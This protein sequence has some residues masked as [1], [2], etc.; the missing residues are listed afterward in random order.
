MNGL[1]RRNIAKAWIVLAMMAAGLSSSQPLAA[2]NESYPPLPSAEPIGGGLPELGHLG[3][4]H[5]YT[6]TSGRTMS[7]AGRG[8]G[9]LGIV[10]VEDPTAPR[11][12]GEI[13]FTAERPPE[14]MVDPD[15]GA[16]GGDP[17]LSHGASLPVRWPA[18]PEA[19]PPTVYAEPAFVREIVLDSVEMPRVAYVAATGPG[20]GAVYVVDVSD[21][22]HLRQAAFVQLRPPPSVSK[23][24]GAVPTQEP[25]WVPVYVEPTGLTKSGNRLFAATNLGLFA[26]DVTDPASPRLVSPEPAWSGYAAAVSSDTDGSVIVV[27]QSDAGNGLWVLD[28]MAGETVTDR[29][30]VELSDDPTYVT[31]RAVAA[32]DGWYAVADAEKGVVVVHP[33]NS[34]VAERVVRYPVPEQSLDVAWGD[35]GLLYVAQS[36]DIGGPGDA[37]PEM[38]YRLRGVRVIDPSKPADAPEDQWTVAFQPLT[39]RVY[40]LDCCESGRVDVAN[41]SDG[42][43]ILAAVGSE[44]AASTAAPSTPVALAATPAPDAAGTST[45]AGA[46][47]PIAAVVVLGLTAASVWAFRRV[48][49]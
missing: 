4:G 21:P 18:Q 6:I 31:S 20:D 11:L 7:F 24:L 1:R 9:G 19:T 13:Y 10:D 27:G 47:V 44:A 32:R 14:L 49:R 39:E 38:A 25:D 41:S 46:L 22:D 29:E 35:D 5:V 15:S 30:F 16:F 34:G 33:R 42:L 12:R 45:G 17:G 37:Y 43:R 48:R 28:P 23:H 40:G 36:H 26:V 3:L 8:G 2:Q